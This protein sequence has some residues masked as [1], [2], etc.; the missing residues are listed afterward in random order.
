MALIPYILVP[1]PLWLITYL[2]ALA[3]VGGSNEHPREF[4]EE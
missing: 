4:I 3:N 2:M 1:Y